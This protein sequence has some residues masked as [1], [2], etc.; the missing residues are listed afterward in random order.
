MRLSTIAGRLSDWTLQLKIA[1]G[2]ICK[3]K[4]FGK[5]ARLY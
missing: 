4:E 3:L 5:L 1:A 2:G